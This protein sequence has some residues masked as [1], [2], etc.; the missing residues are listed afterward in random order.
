M[1]WS[2]SFGENIKVA[3]RTHI[4]TITPVHINRGG[5]GGWTSMFSFWRAKPE[6]EMKKAIEE[7]VAADR[8]A[9]YEEAVQLYAAGIEKMMIVL[10]SRW[11][12]L[13]SSPRLVCA[14]P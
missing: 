7:A 9:R 14:K 13:F 1:N 5:G 8:E 6:D 2:C 12:V 3:K 4:T 10:N 11:S